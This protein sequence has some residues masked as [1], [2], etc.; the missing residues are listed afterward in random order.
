[1]GVKIDLQPEYEERRTRLPPG[2]WNLSRAEKRVVCNSFYD[3]RVP[4]GCIAERYIVEEVVEFCIEHLSNVS[5]V[6][7]P[8]SQKMGL[9]KPLSGC[10]VSLVYLDLLNQAHLYVLENTEEVLLYIE[11]HMIHIK[12][13]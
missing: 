12:T 8:S 11:E 3:M 13:T 7:V 4:E 2:P 1:M 9:S 6:E 10:I 5:T